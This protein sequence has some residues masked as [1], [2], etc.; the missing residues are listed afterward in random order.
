MS[1][2][3]SLQSAKALLPV[4][5]IL[6]GVL[7][8]P[9]AFAEPKVAAPGGEAIKKAQGMIRQLSQEKYALEAEKVAWLNEKATLEAKLKS[10]ET[11]VGRLQTLPAELERYKAGL[12]AVRGNLEAQLSQQRQREQALVQ[13]HNEVVIKARDIRD[14]NNLLVQAVKEREQWIAQCTDLAQQLRKVNLDILNQYKD[15]GL[16]QQLAELDPLTGIGQVRTETVAEEYRYKL[17][18]L[19]ITPFEA[20]APVVQTIIPV[21]DGAEPANDTA[22]AVQ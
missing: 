17:Q 21:K 3:F 2:L 19:K 16:L 20:T 8:G 15:K 7:A 1:R 9:A 6:L 4:S 13:K 5:A 10:L 11:T 12:E 18:Q 22:E 14:D